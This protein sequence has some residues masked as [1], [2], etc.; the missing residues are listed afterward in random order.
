DCCPRVTPPGVEIYRDSS[1]TLSF[2]E[3]DGAEELVSSL[4]LCHY[5]LMSTYCRNL[6]LFAM[7]FI[8]SKTLHIEV[9]T[10]LF[11]VL[12]KIDDDGCRIVGYFSKASYKLSEIER[13]IG[14]PEHPLSDLGLYTYRKYWKSSILCYL[15]YVAKMCTLD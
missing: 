14:S 7:L 5:P 6:C 13:K 10:F 3:V 15:R 12:T 8:S 2:F 11:Y 9:G 4:G 1:K